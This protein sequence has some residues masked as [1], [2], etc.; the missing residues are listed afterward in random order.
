ML[1]KLVLSIMFLM[2]ITVCSQDKIAANFKYKATYALT[3]SLDSTDIENKKSEDMVL[4]LGDDV[5]S[6][7]SKAKIFGNTVVIRGNTGHSSTA[8]LTDFQYI[9][10]KNLKHDFLAYTLEIV[11][12]FLY[13]KESLNLFDWKLHEETKEIKG[14]NAQKA[15]MVYSGREYT[16]WFSHETPISDGPFKFNGLPGLILE[17]ADSESHY[18]FELKSFEKLE[19][20]VPFKTNFKQYIVTTKEKLKDVNES[21]RKDPL[22]YANARNVTISIS[23]EAYQKHKEMLRERLEKEN[24]PI[25]ND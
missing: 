19:P 23:P 13:Y 9:I 25:E 21:Y 1:K 15:T 14:Y 2:S 18:V 17:I 12:D 4:F 10:I 22:P 24:N 8:S 11:E 5:S 6:Y 3:Y 16:A 20:N 7:S